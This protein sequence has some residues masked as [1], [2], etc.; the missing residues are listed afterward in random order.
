MRCCRPGRTWLLLLRRQVGELGP[1]LSGEILGMLLVGEVAA[2]WGSTSSRRQR[3]GARLRRLGWATRTQSTS[4]VG[5][6][7]VHQ[8]G[9]VGRSSG[10]QICFKSRS[11]RFR[12]ELT[13]CPKCEAHPL[14]RLH[15]FRHPICLAEVNFYIRP[16]PLWLVAVDCNAAGQVQTGQNWLF[17]LRLRQQHRISG[18]P[19]RGRT[20]IARTKIRGSLSITKRNPSF[21]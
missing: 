13:R 15:C 11:P 14:V 17:A 3:R 8:G 16:V 7:L 10:A 2:S 4:C 12:P 19:L 6:T 18:S 20:I 9:G 21:L 5:R 1:G